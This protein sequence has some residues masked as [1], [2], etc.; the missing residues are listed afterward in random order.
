MRAATRVGVAAVMIFGL[1]SIAACDED[2]V[3]VSESSQTLGVE[4]AGFVSTYRQVALSLSDSRASTYSD[5]E[6]V[7]AGNAA[8][9]ALAQGATTDD[10]LQAVADALKVTNGQDSI[11]SLMTLKAAA[12]TSLCPE[13]LNPEVSSTQ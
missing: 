5:D 9:R 3:S 12:E 6:I 2:P 1:V 10:V 13:H 7:A 4:E 11:G 8:C